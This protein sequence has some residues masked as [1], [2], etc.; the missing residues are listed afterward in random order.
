MGHHKQLVFRL[1]SPASRYAAVL[2]FGG[3]AYALGPAIPSVRLPLAYD[4]AVIGYLAL[5]L[6]RMVAATPEDT[7]HLARENEPSNLATLAGAVLFSATGLAGV[8]FLLDRAA[9]GP[10]WR[11]AVQSGL[12]LLAVFL[13]WLMVHVFFGIHYSR[14]YYDEAAHDPLECR[15]GLVFPFEG[16]ADYWDFMY[17]SFTIAMCY[18][19]SDISIIAANMRRFTLVHAILSFFYV[20]VVIGLVVEVM[21]SRV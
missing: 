1:T 10:A 14:L 18:Q 3:L 12:S 11:M 4:L 21:S 7:F 13:S 15:G 2:A 17:Y 20:M 5:L 16:R 9:D 8:G 6:V 19:T